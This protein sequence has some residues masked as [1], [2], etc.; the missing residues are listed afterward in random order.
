[1]LVALDAAPA[2]SIRCRLDGERRREDWR[3]YPIRGSLEAQTDGLTLV[4]M[5]VGEID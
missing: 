2:G 1:V 4:D 5:F 3:D